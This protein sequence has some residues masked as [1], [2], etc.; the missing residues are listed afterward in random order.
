[1]STPLS[2]GSTLTITTGNGTFAGTTTFTVSAAAPGETTQSA[3]GSLTVSKRAISVTAAANTKTYDGTASAAATPTITSG[4]LVNGNTAG[5]SEAYNDKN[6]G[7]GKTL[8]PSGSVSDGNSGN[9]YAVTFV[10]TTNGVINARAITVTAAANTKTYDASTSAAAT[11]TITSGSLASGDTAG[12]SE[13][14]NNKNAGT[15][16]TLTPSGSVSDGNSGNNYA[17]TFVSATTGVINARALT[18]SLTGSFTVANKVYDGTASATITTRTV[19]GIGA[20]D[21]SLVGGAATFADKSV[22][23]G[24]TVTGTGFS[25]SGADAGNYSL[26]SNTLTATA[27]ITP[28]AL[29]V[30]AAVVSKVYDGTTSA[31]ATLSDDR[32]VGDVLTTSFTTASFVDKKVGTAKSVSV[33]GI[34]ISGADAGNYTFN[35]TTSASADIT[36]KTLTGGFTAFNK[37]YDGTTSA[38]IASRTVAGAVGGDGVSLSGG[39]ATFGDKNAGSAKTVSG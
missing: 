27:N 3:N 21:V 29:T 23:N 6:A 35:T 5:F 39:S 18:V 31:T 15:G 7:T 22:G 36:A 26:V 17:V 33:S 38:A 13:T 34:S 16:K 1:G 30:S 37:A 11:P 2:L 25:L 28:K 24:K 8:T 20:D 14:Y 4:S 32:V 19:S 10:N 9:N 12:F